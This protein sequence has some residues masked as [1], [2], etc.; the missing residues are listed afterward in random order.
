MAVQDRIQHPELLLLTAGA[1]GG[2]LWECGGAAGGGTCFR[3]CNSAVRLARG[4]TPSVVCSL[5]NRPPLDTYRRINSNPGSPTAAVTTLCQRNTT[6]RNRRASPA[7]GPRG[8][9]IGRLEAVKDCLPAGH[10]SVAGRISF[11]SAVPSARTSAA[12]AGSTSSCSNVRW[13]RVSNPHRSGR[14]RPSPS[15]CMEH[16]AHGVTS[17]AAAVGSRRAPWMLRQRQPAP[18]PACQEELRWL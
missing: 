1:G 17:G 7:A 4:E 18:Q 14:T 3:H 5:S 6:C 8:P 13:L 16:D 12:A 15:P 11:C 9:L 10:P 2:S